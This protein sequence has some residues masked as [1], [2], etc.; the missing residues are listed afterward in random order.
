MGMSRVHTVMSTPEF[1]RTGWWADE[2]KV[3]RVYQSHARG[4][5]LH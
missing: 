4:L 3:H 2:R 1:A 5:V